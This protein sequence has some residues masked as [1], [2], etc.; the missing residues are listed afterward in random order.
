[1]KSSSGRPAH[2]PGSKAAIAAGSLLLAAGPGAGT[3]QLATEACQQ[4]GSEVVALKREVAAL[5]EKIGHFESV[6]KG[7]LLFQRRVVDV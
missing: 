5:K 6:L 7:R 1:M 3:E 2:Q 4:E